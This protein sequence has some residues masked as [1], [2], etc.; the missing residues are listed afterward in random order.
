MAFWSQLWQ[1]TLVVSLV[2]FAG[3][4]VLVTIGGARDIQRLL[5]RLR[6]SE[7]GKEDG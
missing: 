1:V 7:Q 6:E 2:V 5:K 3:M 4:A